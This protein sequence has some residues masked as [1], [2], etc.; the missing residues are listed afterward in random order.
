M[1]PSIALLLWGS[2]LFSF[3]ISCAP[4]QEAELPVLLE[5]VDDNYRISENGLKNFCV[6][7]DID[8][9]NIR[10]WENHYLIQLPGKD[11]KASINS[12]RQL[13]PELRL[14]VYDQPMYVFDRQQHCGE[15]P[16]D[17]WDQVVWSTSLVADTAM[18]EEYMRYHRTQFDEW[19][20]VAGGFCRAQ[21][22]RLLLYRS[23]RQLLILINYPKGEDYD[24]LNR[25]TT[26]DNPRMDEWNALMSRYQVAI[27]QAP[28][29]EVW[30]QFTQLP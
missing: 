13:Y 4:K 5:I 29:D 15:A 8:P 20:E 9:C 30:I 6:S 26:L 27:D 10:Q 1:K 25:L 2:I 28:T 17:D 12:F 24:A 7:L 18:Q 16:V 23:G 14:Q 21:F 3:F 11:A 22:Q 19:P